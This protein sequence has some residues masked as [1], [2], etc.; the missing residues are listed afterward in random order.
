MLAPLADTHAHLA[1][2]RLLPEVR[3]VVE[4]AEAAGVQRILA[5]GVD[6][7]SSAAS[8]G[9]AERFPSV[10]AAVG[11]HPHEVGS[12]DGGAL[13]DLR[14]LAAHPKV[15]AVGEIG[16]DYVRNLAPRD[17]QQTSFLEQLAL[18]A[19]LDLPVVVHNR[20]ADA[21]VLR[22]IG[23][24]ERGP[25]LLV[26]AGVLHCFSGGPDL[27]QEAI[28]QGFFLSFAGNLTFPR[29][30]G[31]RRTAAILPGDWLLVETDS[32]ELAPVP[33]R[34]RT[35]QPANLSLVAQALADARGVAGDAIAATTYANAG[36][37]FG[38]S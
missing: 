6:V 24:V 1:D 38:W 14:R 26:R 31:L 18:A 17:V 37:L 23:S 29:A 12:F 16:L 32:P 9:L 10:W 7:P 5:V 2:P 3:G 13:A 22:L 35:N 21:D 27:A 28:R 34:G 15:V 11:V 8:V 19:E 33:L 4:R 30:R 20:D 36:R 25:R